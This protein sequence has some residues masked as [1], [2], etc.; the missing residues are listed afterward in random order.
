M[1]NSKK[2]PQMAACRGAFC[3]DRVRGGGHPTVM[4]S[5]LPVGGAGAQSSHTYEA[6][7]AH[8]RSRQSPPMDSMQFSSRAPFGWVAFHAVKAGE[9]PAR[10]RSSKTRPSL[11]RQTSSF[12]RSLP[13]VQ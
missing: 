11:Q 4:G 2:K 8:G 3:A 12:S 13:P 6:A 10:V 1:E 9:S 5:L 7:D